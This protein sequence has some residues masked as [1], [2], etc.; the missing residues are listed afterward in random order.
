MNR[1]PAPLVLVVA[2]AG[3]TGCSV[4]RFEGPEI[5]SPPPGFF[6]QPGTSQAYRMFPDREL[7]FH[8][9]WVHTDLGGV[10]T[11]FIDGYRGTATVDDALTAMEEMRQRAP[12]PDTR[13]GGIEALTIDGHSAWGWEERVESVERGLVDV[14]Y[15]AIV[16][17]D[18]MTYTVEFAS[19]EPSIKLASPDTLRATVASFAIGRT[20]WNFPMLAL[21]LGLMLLMVNSMVNRRKARAQQL[22]SINLVQVKK[23]DEE[24]SAESEGSVPVGAASGVGT[25][26]P[27]SGAG[28]S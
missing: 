2:L 16:A 26:V 28:P 22:R 5:Q 19:G 23:D 13:F 9:A 20:T 7:A 8:T 1:R 24:E 11:I 12:D 14:A 17:Y 3:L 10:S 6:Q 4:P 15:R 21:G 25:S 18:T 27:G